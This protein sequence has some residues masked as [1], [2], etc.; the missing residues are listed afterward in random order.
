METSSIVIFRASA[1]RSGEDSKSES[2]AEFLSKKVE[3]DDE[4]P[5]LVVSASVKSKPTNSNK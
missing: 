3:E 4:R 1:Y 5:V 2:D